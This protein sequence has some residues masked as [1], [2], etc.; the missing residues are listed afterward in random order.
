MLP[1]RD[2]PAK[3]RRGAPLAQGKSIRSVTVLVFHDVPQVIRSHVIL[4]PARADCSVDHFLAV[5]QGGLRRRSRKSYER[6]GG[7]WARSGHILRPDLAPV[8]SSARRGI[9]PQTRLRADYI[10]VRLHGGGVEHPGLLAHVPHRH[11]LCT[12]RHLQPCADRDRQQL[13]RR[14]RPGETAG[15]LWQPGRRGQD[16]RRLYRLPRLGADHAGGA[17]GSH[18]VARLCSNGPWRVDRF[19]PRA[20]LAATLPAPL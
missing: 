9:H 7:F 20:F 16:D 15:G 3:G 13:R 17:A 10:R 1:E 6:A 8:G 5:P 18:L 19:P 14:Q 4:G 11:L 2:P 12:W